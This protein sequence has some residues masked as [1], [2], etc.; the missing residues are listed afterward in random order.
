MNEIENKLK[1]IKVKLFA[2]LCVVVII[3]VVLLII[4]NNFVLSYFYQ[5]NKVVNLKDVYNKISEYYLY[6]NKTSIEEE[7]DKIAINNNFDILIR[8]NDNISIYTSNKDYY[9]AIVGIYNGVGIENDIIEEND[10]YTISQFKD[11]TTNI[12]YISECQ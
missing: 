6:E 8:S 5:Y 1:S 12:K 3:I 11:K 9:S 2:S 10:K 7:L 4:L